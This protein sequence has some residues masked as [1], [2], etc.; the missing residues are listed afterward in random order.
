MYLNKR[1][2]LILV[3]IITVLGIAT[4]CSSV[5]PYQRVYL[6]DRFMGPQS[7]DQFETNVFNYREGGIQSGAK[8]GKGGCGCN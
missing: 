6:N 3:P 4:A 7:L 8:T 1:S 2:L 5:K